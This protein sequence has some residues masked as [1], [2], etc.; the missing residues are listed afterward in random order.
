V[1]LIQPGTFAL[2]AYGKAILTRKHCLDKR[3]FHDQRKETR[4][5]ETTFSDLAKHR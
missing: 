4:G 3:S 1:L 5:A 2:F